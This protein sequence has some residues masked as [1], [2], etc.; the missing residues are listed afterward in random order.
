MPLQGAI[1]KLKTACALI[2]THMSLT[3]R[4]SKQKKIV[5]MIQNVLVYM[6]GIAMVIMNSNSA[7]I[8]S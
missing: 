8:I 1:L 7:R 5:T 2:K 3:I 4:L 6:T